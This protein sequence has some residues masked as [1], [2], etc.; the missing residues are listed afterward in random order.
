MRPVGWSA[1]TIRRRA[2]AA[3]YG[4]PLWLCVCSLAGVPGIGAGLG[5]VP[6][7]VSCARGRRIPA[8]LVCMV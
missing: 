1:R 6:V 8:F 2:P 5:L 4:L 3:V 7:A